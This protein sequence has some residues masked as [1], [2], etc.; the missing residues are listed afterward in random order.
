VFGKKDYQ[1]WRLI[2][3]MVSDRFD[4]ALHL[5]FLLMFC[6]GPLVLLRQ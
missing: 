2:C 1:Q 4:I 6:F 3:R 5:Q